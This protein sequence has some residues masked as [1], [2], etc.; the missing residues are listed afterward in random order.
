LSMDYDGHERIVGNTIGVK[1]AD[2]TMKVVMGGLAGLD[3]TPFDYIQAMVLW[4]QY[5]RKDQRFPADVI[6]LHHYSNNAPAS[7]GNPTSG[8]SP[9]DDNLKAKLLTW[10]TWR[11]TWMPDRELW[12]SEFGYDT[13]GASPQ[14]AP[15]IGTASGEI[16]QAQWIIRSYL[17][18]A[19]A[20]FERA[21]QFMFRDVTDNSP[22]TYAT[23]GFTSSKD[24]GWKPKP[25]W[26]YVYTMKNRLGE[27]S[28]VSDSTDTTQS[29][30]VAK[31]KVPASNT[32]AGPTQGYV[33][34]CPT[35]SGHTVSGYSLQLDG[36]PPSAM[37]VT[38][39]VGSITGVETK[40]TISQGRVGVD[41]SETPIFVLVP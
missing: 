8:I 2:P 22:Y 18:I 12:L 19:A 40:L 33:V 10:N 15:A 41:V 11:N 39:T 20:G 1:N 23:S 17:A 25:S 30:S 34:W 29:V 27:M 24:S 6:N 35:S 32:V 26:Y 13:N 4:A 3:S 7:G 21:Q 37:Q 5:H 31:F 38:L 16:V 36:N 28:F 14:K 9:E